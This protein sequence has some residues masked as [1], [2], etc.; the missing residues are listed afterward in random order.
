VS[1][2][3]RLRLVV[4]ST[5]LALT[6]SCDSATA[7][8]RTPLDA[9]GVYLLASVSGRGATSGTFLLTADGRAERRVHD[10][11]WGAAESVATGTYSLDATGISFV[12]RENGSASSYA[13]PVRGEWKGS[14]FSIRYP[15]PADGPD[16]VENY[17]RL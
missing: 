12:L 5:L 3:S 17:Q 7:P 4:V 8:S 2:H 15:D 16:I 1:L 6:A 10:P 9:A 13:W 14:S 11:A